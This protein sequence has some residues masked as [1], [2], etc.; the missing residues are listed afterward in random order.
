MKRKLRQ[1]CYS[2]ALV[3][4]FTSVASAQPFCQRFK[5]TDKARTAVFD[6][7][8]QELN[9]SPEQKQQITEQK[10]KEKEEALALKEKLSATRAAL[11]KELEKE[12][13]D[14]AK[15]NALISE[16]K[17]LIGKRIEN[18][19]KGVLSLKEILTPEQFRIL[20]DKRMRFQM[21]KGGRR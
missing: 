13:I 4:F 17:E 7:T 20:H 21:S 2:M 19:I 5:R 11:S 16:M 14:R 10:N 12:N 9:L 8:I 15:I 18:K 3:L 1:F 6:N